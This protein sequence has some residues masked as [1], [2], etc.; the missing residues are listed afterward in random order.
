MTARFAPSF[1]RKL[2]AAL[3]ALVLATTPLQAEPF[4]PPGTFDNFVEGWYSHQ[5]TALEEQPIWQGDAAKEVLRFTWLRTW[6]DPVAIR[7]EVTDGSATLHLKSSDGEGGYEPGALVI[8]ESR[9]LS[10]AEF[11]EMRTRLDFFARCTTPPE[12]MPGLDGAQWIFEF[13]SGADYCLVEEWSP[14]SGPWRDAGVFLLTLAGYDVPE[15][16][17]Y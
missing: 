3:A 9:A 11:A 16:D 5:L 13:R 10:P 7:I 15:S 17:I 2:A 8:D 6:G 4:F 12:V 14:T 1:T